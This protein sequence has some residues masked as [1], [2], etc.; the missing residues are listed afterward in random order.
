M[1]FDYPEAAEAYQY[2]GQ[3]MF[4]DSLLVAPVTTPLDPLHHLSKK[5]VWLPEGEWVEWS[6]GSRFNGP[7]AIERNF[8]LD[9]VPVF[10]KAGAIIPMQ[11]R[12]KF[13]NEKPVDPLIVTVFPGQ[14]GSMRLYEDA[15]NSLGYKNGEAAWTTISTATPDATTLVVRVQA[16]EGTYPGM[17]VERG[18]EI[19]LFE[20]WPPDSVTFNGQSIGFN[21]DPDARAGWRYDGD[22]LTTIIRLPRIA[23]A[24]PAELTVK[25]SPEKV[26]KLKL[27]D[28]AV[29]RLAHIR[30]LFKDVNNSGPDSLLRLATTGRR[31]ELK[32][33]T[34]VSELAG[35]DAARDAM[36]NDLAKTTDNSWSLLW[37]LRVSE[38]VNKVEADR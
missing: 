35:Y 20:V 16:V 29:G 17:P 7:V 13:S 6:T 11:P 26:A 21:S 33:E 28:G 14:P 2:T 4:G 5:A 15:G 12:M 32:P 10:L 31:L 38:T 1:Y 23:V 34:A 18:Y 22:S 3:Y 36:A 27:L 37:T 24:T 8:A 19:R 9:E 25:I 30:R